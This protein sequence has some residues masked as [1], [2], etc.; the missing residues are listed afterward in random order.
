MHELYVTAKKTLVTVLVLLCVLLLCMGIGFWRGC[1]YQRAKDD[2]SARAERHEERIESAQNTVD[3]VA[4]GLAGV[5]EQVQ[6]AR[7][8]I[9]E[10][11]TGLGE[12]GKVG[13]RISGTSQDIART[14]GR[15]EER[16]RRIESILSEAEKSGAVLA[17][18]YGCY[19]PD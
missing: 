15:I 10:S 16:I 17:G 4:D 12:L 5:A 13:D 19:H 18:D 1:A 6:S 9:D 7:T 11:I 14:A 8:E 3:A 2:D